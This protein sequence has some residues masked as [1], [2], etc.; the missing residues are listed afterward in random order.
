MRMTW[1]TLN[2]CCWVVIIPSSGASASSCSIRLRIS[3]ITCITDIR[4]SACNAIRMTLNTNQ[5]FS[6]TCIIIPRNTLALI[7]RNRNSI[8]VR[9]RNTI[10]PLSYTSNTTSMAQLAVNRISRCTFINI[11]RQTLTSY[12]S[13]GGCISGQTSIA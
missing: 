12:S 6:R 1:Q 5:R 4:P 10:I 13:T 3:L 2:S 8:N 9:T 11:P 7:I